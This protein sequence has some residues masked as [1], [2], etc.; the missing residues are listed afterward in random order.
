MLAAWGEGGSLGGGRGGLL[1]A[2]LSRQRLW[3]LKMKR[4]GRCKLCGGARAWYVT[5]TGRVK[6]STLCRACM[7]KRREHNARPTRYT[8]KRFVRPPN[9]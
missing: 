9:L 6:V 4:Q 8:P 5:T 2:E 1:M 7:V 3:Q